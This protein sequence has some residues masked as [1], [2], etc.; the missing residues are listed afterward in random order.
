MVDYDKDQHVRN[1]QVEVYRMEMAGAEL[2]GRLI[3]RNGRPVSAEEAAR[4]GDADDRRKGRKRSPQK[5]SDTVL[6]QLDQNAA[7]LFDFKLVGRELLA[8]R[9]AYVVAVSPKGDV[10]PASMEEKVMLRIQGNLWIDEQDYEIA[11]LDVRL[12]ESVGIGWGGWLGALHDLS[13][14]VERSSMPDGGW[15]NSAVRLYIHFRQLLDAKCFLYEET[16]SDMQP[17]KKSGQAG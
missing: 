14:S 4:D 15:A 11:K 5:K 6:V 8:G 13:F 3:S 7:K 16:V 9:S 1:Q 12:T 10:R 17:I 2:R